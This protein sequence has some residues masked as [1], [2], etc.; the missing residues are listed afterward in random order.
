MARRTKTEYLIGPDLYLD[1]EEFTL[2][3]GRRLTNEL[4]EQIAEETWAEVRR[5]T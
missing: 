3:D 1:E 2:R 5:R 4:A